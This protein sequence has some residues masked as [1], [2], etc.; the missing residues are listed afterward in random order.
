MINLELNFET[1]E[2]NEAYIEGVRHGI[3]MYARYKDGKQVVGVQ[4]VPMKDIH[5]QLDKLRES[6]HEQ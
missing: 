4:E 2:E 3:W 6:L 1:K 5:N